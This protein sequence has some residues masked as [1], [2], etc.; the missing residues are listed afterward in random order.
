MKIFDPLLQHRKALHLNNRTQER[1]RKN[2][3]RIRKGDKGLEMKNKDKKELQKRK[4]KDIK[5]T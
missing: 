2:K 4:M 3:Q 1:V 5:R